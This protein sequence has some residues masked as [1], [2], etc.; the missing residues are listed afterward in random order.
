MGNIWELDFYSRPILDA[1][2]KKVWEVLICESPTDVLTKVDSLFR[3][4]Q[5]CPST[6]VNSVWLRQALQEAI[7]KAG[8]APIKIRFFRRQMNNMITKA[9]QDMGIPALPSRKTL[10]LNQWIQQR[11]EEVYPQEPGYEQV[12]NSSVR[13]ERPLPQRLPD[14]LEGKQ[15][16]FVSLGSSDITDMPEWEIA[17]GEAFPLELAGLSPEIPIPGILIFSP[18]ALPIAGWMSGLELAYLRLDSNRNNQGDRLVLE[19]GGT[20]SWILANLRTPQLLAEA[21]GF[22]EAKQKA[23]G[24]HFIGVQSD[25]QSQSFAGFW[26]LKEI[27]L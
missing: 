13:L 10:V 4:A 6:Q 3:Y 12:T 5:Y 19:T 11:M 25:P 14:A 17:F 24:V 26:L 23:D 7:E 8:V 20:E 18:R 9:C 16:T 22:E 21:K 27:N 15:W 2:Q 1:N